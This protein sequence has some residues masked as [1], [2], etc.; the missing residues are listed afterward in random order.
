MTMAIPDVRP[1]TGA[2]PDKPLPTVNEVLGL[3][4]EPSIRDTAEPGDATTTDDAPVDD[5]AAV[6]GTWAFVDLEAVLAGDRQRMTPTILRRNDGRHL[7]YAGR[8]NGV[9]ADSGV[10]KGWIALV[11]ALDHLDHGGHVL[12]IDFEDPNAELVVERLLALGVDPDVIRERVHYLNPSDP[13]TLATAAVLVAQVE[14]YGSCLVVVDSVGES[15]GL[16]GYDEDKDVQVDEWKRLLPHPFE[17]AGHTVLLIDHSTKARDNPLHPSGSKRKRAL[18][19]GASWNVEEITPFDREHPGKLRLVCAKDR[20]GNFR[21]KE[22]GAWV[23]VDPTGDRLKIYLEAPSATDAKPNA[24]AEFVLVLGRVVG[25]LKD[26]GLAGLGTSD[27]RAALRL[28]A[29]GVRN[30]MIDD[31]ATYAA[32]VGAITITGGDKPGVKKVHRFARQLTD[33]DLKDLEDE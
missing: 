16:Q 27:L 30:Q 31:A 33:A 12:W 32:R 5:V 10:G 26:A 8:T 2:P 11:A 25:V 15:L 13:A 17:R 18:I 4:P 20:H 23:H 19:S 28:K 14:P 9:H 7:V 22:V 24:N 29:K 21:R 6:L 3:A 1:F